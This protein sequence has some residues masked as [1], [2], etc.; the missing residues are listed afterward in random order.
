[1][2]TI[3]KTVDIPA[4]RRLIV[5]IPPEVPAGKVSVVLSF[6]QAED[7][8]PP[9]DSDP[10]SRLLSHTFPTIEEIKA[11]AAKKA[12]KREAAINATGVVPLQKYWGCL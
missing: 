8:P 11:E 7:T 3:K 2:F 12:A 5:D 4:D 6:P 10:L 9:K 1:M